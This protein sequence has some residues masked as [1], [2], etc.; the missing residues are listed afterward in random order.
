MDSTAPSMFVSPIQSAARA[1]VVLLVL[2]CGLVLL[3]WGLDVRLLR[4]WGTGLTAVN[5]LTAVT[6]L[7]ASFAIL[8]QIRAAQRPM[9]PAL[10]R[11]ALVAAWL[12]MFVGAVTV[13]GFLLDRN[14]GLDQILFGD[15]L[16][17]NRV[18]PNTGISFILLGI[19][20]AFLNRRA[21]REYAQAFAL[22]PFV[23]AVISIAGYVLGADELTGFARLIPM[24]L[25]TAVCFLFASLGVLAVHPDRGITAVLTS[26]YAGGKAARRL[27]PLTLILPMA[28]AFIRLE[29]QRR[30]YYSLE[31]G[32][33]A[34][35][36]LLVVIFGSIIWLLSH[37]QNRA[38]AALH[39]A[40]DAAEAGT[41]AKAAFLANMSHEIRTPLNAILGMSDLLAATNLDREQREYVETIGLSGTHLLTVI[42][43]ILDFSKIESG[44]LQLQSRPLH[45][46]SVVEESLDL[47]AS[48]AGE[49][50]LELVYYISPNVP[51]WLVG[52]PARVRQILLN[53]LSNAAKFTDKGEIAVTVDV[54]E[55]DPVAPLV[56]FRVRDTGKGI[57]ADELPL[58]FRSFSQLDDSATRAAGG[59]GLGLAI[60]RQLATLMGGSCGVESEVGVG[61]T[62]HFTVRLPRGEAPAGAKKAADGALTGVR[63]L[64]VDDNTTNRNLLQALSNRWGMA[65]QEAESGQA[66]LRLLEGPDPFDVILLDFVLGDTDGVSLARSIRRLPTRAATPML[67]LSSAGRRPDLAPDDQALFR[68]VL[69]KPIRQSQLLNAIQ[70][71]LAE[72]KSPTAQQ[73]RPVLTRPPPGRLKILLVEDNPVNRRVA[74]RMLERLGATADVA[75]NGQEALDRMDE[76]NYDIVFMDVQMPIMDGLEATRRIRRRWMGPGR[77]HIVAMTAEAMQGDKERCLEAGM[78]DYLSKPV[79]L[80]ALRAVLRLPRTAG[81]GRGSESSVGEA[82]DLPTLDRLAQDLGGRDALG[83]LVESFL[84]ESSGLLTDL[85]NAVAKGDAP[86][87]RRASH[88]LKSTSMTFGAIPLGNLAQECEELAIAGQLGEI[89]SRLSRA[90]L[91][92]AAVQAAR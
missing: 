55:D 20:L 56:M 51:E 18:A 48:R 58:L 52:D 73:G 45:V 90:E 88:T 4:T 91:L 35:A 26:P 79:S 50:G 34:Y 39:R 40:R 83:S 17:T 46:P 86:T 27:L 84:S 49:K 22:G 10:R 19:A 61:S 81:V 29:G 23:V 9:G 12:V 24:A 53:L 2:I 89:A 70:E 5:P 62:F 16:G 77:P 33:A 15:R 87:A 32:I 80:D 67:L 57:R 13:L 8:V 85:R 36:V 82:I 75:K 42:N 71:A 7:C 37:A 72:T 68:L 60:S 1:F 11:S 65:S 92:F 38:D 54:A 30:G 3:G 44:S 66:A 59:T 74:L 76:R 14:F 41:R 31:F 64:V 47:V 69:P 21:H 43:D 25:P 78:D 63:A 6:F 28:L